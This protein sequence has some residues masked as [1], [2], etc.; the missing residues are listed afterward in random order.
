[1]EMADKYNIKGGQ[2]GA[3]GDSAVASFFEIYNL[4]ALSGGSVAILALLRESKKLLETALTA[5]SRRQITIKADGVTVELKGSNDVEDALR[6][7]EQIAAKREG[8]RKASERQK[9]PDPSE[10]KKLL[11]AALG[12]K[13]TLSH[14][15][16]T[17]DGDADMV[18]AQ[19]GSSVAL[20]LEAL[21]K[22]LG[23][24]RK[25]MRREAQTPAHDLALAKIAAAES[26]A[27]KSDIVAAFRNLR[28]AG[29]WALE[30]ATTVG[31]EIAA[32]S[33]MQALQ[34]TVHKS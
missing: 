13:D 4:V 3:V 9:L 24:I 19:P 12:G 32:Q 7:F 25:A 6:V 15:F 16:I 20:D 27:M 28:A 33:I 31:A 14:I 34:K 22:E 17:A 26:A 21:A 18:A 11:E 8:S 1:V 29:P 30:V 2:A 10:S 5:R 23:V